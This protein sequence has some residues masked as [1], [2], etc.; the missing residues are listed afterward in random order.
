MVQ[1][2]WYSKGPEEISKGGN[3][4][5][6]KEV[7]HRPSPEVSSALC[8]CR[9]NENASSKKMEGWPVRRGVGSIG[10]P[11]SLLHKCLYCDTGGGWYSYATFISVKSCWV[12]VREPGGAW[13]GQMETIQ[14]AL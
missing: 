5:R 2:R 8:G 3:V 12:P 9:T 11:N 14:V 13:R 1:F 4:D 7:V 6:K 10:G